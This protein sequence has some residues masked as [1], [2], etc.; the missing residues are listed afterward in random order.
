MIGEK[1]AK[2][3]GG[4]KQRLTGKRV[5]SRTQSSA[6]RQTAITLDTKSEAAILESL[7]ILDGRMTVII[8]H[9]LSSIKD[10]SKI[11]VL[12]G[13]QM[14]ET[15][16]YLDLKTQPGSEL[17]RMIAAKIYSRSTLPAWDQVPNRFASSGIF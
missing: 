14:V 8:T 11:Y 13:G 10:A 9:Q 15:G 3:S 4:Q 6:S 1:G 2:L 17:S 5:I 16:G 7:K 12:K